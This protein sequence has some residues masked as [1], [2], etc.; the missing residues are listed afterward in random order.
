[1]R[2]DRCGGMMVSEQIYSSDGQFLA[3]KC[4]L[5]GESVDHIERSPLAWN[6]R[7]HGSY[8]APEKRAFWLTHRLTLSPYRQWRIKRRLEDYRL[9][10]GQFIEVS[11]FVP[12]S[13]LAGTSFRSSTNPPPTIR[14]SL[15]VW[16]WLRLNIAAAITVLTNYHAVF[17][18]IEYF[19]I[20]FF[21]ADPVVWASQSGSTWAQGSLILSRW[22]P[23]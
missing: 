6:Q 15:T 1:M 23:Y 9:K 22:L 7:E 20:H 21:F 12:P 10:T 4:I 2:C 16:I 13:V 3:Y 17:G 14:A 18:R 19:V 8:R 5:C 11:C